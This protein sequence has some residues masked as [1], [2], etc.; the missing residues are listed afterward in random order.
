MFFEYISRQ[1][2]LEYKIDDLQDD[3]SLFINVFSFYD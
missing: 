3:V 1:F 2:Y